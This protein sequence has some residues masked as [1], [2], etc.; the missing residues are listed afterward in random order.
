M[1]ETD[2]LS[3]LHDV[4]TPAAV[5]WWPL[6]P[7]WWAVL[8]ALLLFAVWRA[9]T[10]YRAWQAN[11]YR[12]VALEE[13]TVIESDIGDPARSAGAMARVAALIK[14][15]A[16]CTAPRETVAALSGETWLRYLDRGTEG[17]PFTQGAGRWLPALTYRDDDREVSPEQAREVVSVARR[18]IRGHRTS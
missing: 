11:R 1:D 14:R 2:V 13:L 18:W 15:T 17:A 3:G 5:G 16:L 4:V 7:G 8:V 9:W 12:R 6:A 10:A